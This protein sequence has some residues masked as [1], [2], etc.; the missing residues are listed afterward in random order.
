MAD[1]NTAW[2]SCLHEDLF[3][4]S[5]QSSLPRKLCLDPGIWRLGGNAVCSRVEKRAVVSHLK[6]A[7]GDYSSET[8]SSFVWLASLWNHQ[9]CLSIC[10]CLQKRKGYFLLK[11]CFTS[12]SP[13][14]LLQRVNCMAGHW[15]WVLRSWKG[16]ERFW[17]SFIPTSFPFSWVREVFAC[18]Y[19]VFFPLQHRFLGSQ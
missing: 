17:K 4:A 14:L 8:Q 2:E 19:V 3:A 6:T 12:H 9:F 10:G 15:G 1:Q 13:S 7:A 18:M 11:L 16:K 5:E